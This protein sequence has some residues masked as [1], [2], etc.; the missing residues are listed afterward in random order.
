MIKN[1]LISI[2]A[3]TLLIHMA[4]TAF[5]ASS[6]D[7][8]FVNRFGLREDPDAVLKRTLEGEDFS[9]AGLVSRTEEIF[10]EFFMAVYKAIV[11]LFPEFDPP[12]P[13]KGAKKF[14]G[15]TLTVI[16]LALVATLLIFA[17]VWIIL[18]TGA[19]NWRFK[20]KAVSAPDDPLDLENITHEELWDHAVTFSEEGDYRRAIIY[21]FRSFLMRLENEGIISFK[22]GLTNREILRTMD[23][24][25]PNRATLAKMIPVFN[26]IRYGSGDGDQAQVGLFKELSSPRASLAKN[27]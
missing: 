10:V 15:D 13:Y 25:D 8:P 27:T 4:G 3:L 14:S 18:K 20:T 19:L 6:G 1:L 12:W 5:A 17:L 22:P 9:Y 24:Q 7:G 26:R 21:F 2:I 23:I 16:S 11:D